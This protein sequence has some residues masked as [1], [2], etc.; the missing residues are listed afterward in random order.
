MT[1]KK[2][3]LYLT[4]LAVVF[5]LAIPVLVLVSMGYRMDSRLRLVETGGLHLINRQSGVIVSLDGKTAYTAGVF[6]ENIL[7]RNLVPK[8]YYVRVEKNGYRP[9]NKIIEVKEQRVEVC[10]PLLIPIK[11][12]PRLVPKYV[13]AGNGRNKGYE[14]NEEYS[15]AVK[16]FRGFDKAAQGIIPGWNGGAVKKHKLGPYRRLYKKVLLSRQGNEIFVK[17]TG[18]DEK[19]PFFIVPA[20]DKHR[21]V[22]SSGKK[23][24]SFGFFPGRHDAVLVLLENLN[25]L[26]IEIDTRFKIQNIY[27]VASNCSRFAVKDEFL[28]YFSGGSMYMIDFE[29]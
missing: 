13:R 23:I 2:R 9:W 17:W 18:R 20:G 26:A 1:P 4:G 14:P 3:K 25:L 15:E 19:R 16:V 6:E 27:T 11:L 22:F 24:L 10:Y 8:T 21:L 28:Y 5:V 7:I 12:N 29:S